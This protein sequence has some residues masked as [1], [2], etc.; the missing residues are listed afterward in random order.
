MF[1]HDIFEVKMLVTKSNKD[2]QRKLE[3]FELVKDV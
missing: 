1:W 2:L 3:I